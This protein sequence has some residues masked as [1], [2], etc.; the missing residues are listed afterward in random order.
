M[1][2]LILTI[3]CALIICFSTSCDFKIIEESN[4]NTSTIT[5]SSKQNVS[6]I[7]G[8]SN[9]PAYSV[10]TEENVSVYVSSVALTATVEINCTVNYSYYGYKTYG[11]HSQRELI[12][13]SESCE[14][15]G[16]VINEDGYVVTNAHVV[17]IEGASSVSSFTYNSREIYVNY[18]DSDVSIPC[19]V[20]AYDEDLDLCILKMN[21]TNISNIQY[22]TFFNHTSPT[23]STYSNSNAVKLLYGETVL[24]VGNAEGY[25]MSVTK[26][27]VS[28]PVRNFDGTYAI[29]T[30]AAINAGN[31]GGPL[32]N[33]YAAV[34]GINAFKIVSS[35]TSESLG[36]AIPSYTVLEYIDS[37]ETSKSLTIKTYTTTSRSYPGAE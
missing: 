12:T 5:D 29:Q 19:T 4:D 21:T 11:F 8:T 27:V 34:I 18:A 22:L 35:S 16:F 28:A 26:G 9:V 15:T 33:A 30:D 1:K 17:C 6:Y 2:K 31:S 24:A 25:G 37:V 10:V 36:F 23:S 20:V 13:S 3:I 32:L 14:A 7:I